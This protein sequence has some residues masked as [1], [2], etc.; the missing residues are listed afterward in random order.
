MNEDY[1]FTQNGP[2]RNFFV[3]LVVKL[4]VQVLRNV[5]HQLILMG[6]HT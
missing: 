3:A 2:G 4:E 5:N 6:F 1:A